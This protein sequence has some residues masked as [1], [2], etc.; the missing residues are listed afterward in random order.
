MERKDSLL[1]TQS[2]ARLLVRLS[3]PATV[4][5]LV[6]ALY[7]L[8]DTIFVGRGV[9]TEAIGG[10]TIAFPFQVIIMAFAG[11]IGFGTASVVSR[12]L[13]SGDRDRACAAAGNAFTVSIGFGLLATV[14]GYALLDPIL[15]LF[16]ATPLLLSYAR[17][18]LSV[19]LAG[20]A[21]I[22]FSLATN[23]IVRAEGRAAVAMITMVL[24]AVANMI[25]DPIFI[26]AL[27]MGIRGAAL[28]TVIAQ[29][30]SFVFLLFFFLS[31]RSSL[32]IRLIHLKPA[33]GVLKEIFAL[34][35]PAFIRQSGMS[36]V[37][38]LVNNLLGRYGGNVYIAVFG[39]IFRILHFVLM[40]LV[41][42]VQGFQPI[43]GYNYG[44]G[45]IDRVRYG[46]RLSLLVS[47]ALAL[48]GFLLLSLLPGPI[49]RIFST[50]P[51]LIRAG[52]PVLRVVV[53][54][55][56]FI[57]IQMIGS[58]YFQA[59]GKARPA[60]FLGLSRQFIFLLPMMIILPLAFGLWGVFAAFP[61]A[62]FLSTLVTGLW[63]WKDVRALRVPAPT[64]PAPGSV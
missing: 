25:L 7:N 10:L 16:G 4:A 53:L 8:V 15:R 63:L 46:V 40:P 47:T 59:V 2:I 34:G 48:L 26:F 37:L 5:M 21:F 62:D 20:S 39:L 13:G 43:T 23:N 50:D 61:A 64:A 30:L 56:P 54:I 35:V 41:G 33:G 12:N 51:T 6:M 3:V 31:G 11:M 22:T 42:L 60:L 36:L 18:Y 19:I 32:K 58:S 1:G 49:F 27:N 14:L 17:D 45:K 44:A 38:I 24:G 28:A 9:G 55:L 57:G 52:M 29:S